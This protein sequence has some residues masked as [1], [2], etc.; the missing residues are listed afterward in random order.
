MSDQQPDS[1]SDNRTQCTVRAKVT[2]IFRELVGDRAEQLSTGL[3]DATFTSTVSKALISE[4]DF[5]VERAQDI[6]FH[7]SDWHADAAFIVAVHLF[8]ER[9]TPAE[10]ED[11]IIAFLSHAPNHVAAAATLFGFP[12]E[13]IFGVSSPES[14]EPTSG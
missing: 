10:I 1:S 7:L 11:G 6:G 13:D 3:C 2:A 12:V 5:A 8:P 4:S 9:F 14:N